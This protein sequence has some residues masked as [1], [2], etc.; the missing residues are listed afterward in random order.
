MKLA[1]FA[2]AVMGEF[3]DIGEWDPF[4]LQGLAAECGILLEEKRTTFCDDPETETGPVCGCREYMADS[5]A[6]AGF[7]CYR[8]SPELE[9]QAKQEKESKA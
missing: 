8:L 7:S 3:P 5:E 1:E 9:A 6:A 4:E 2:K